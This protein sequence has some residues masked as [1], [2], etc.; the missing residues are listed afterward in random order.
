MLQLFFLSSKKRKWAQL[1]AVRLWYFTL[2]K[3]IK[4]IVLI[5]I[6]MSPKISWNNLHKLQSAYT[7]ALSFH[8]RRTTISS[9]EDHKAT[10][11]R[12]QDNFSED[13][14]PWDWDCNAEK[15]CIKI[16][17]LKTDRLLFSCEAAHC[18]KSSTFDFQ[19]FFA[20]INKVLIL[21]ERLG[22]GLKFYDILRFTWYFLFY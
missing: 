1:R 18:R 22:T 14:K 13:T 7:T 5:K 15:R 8:D 9:D 17:R 6:C 21:K 20:S 12:S 16:Q 4:L 3:N 10:T 11:S 19:Q 2:F